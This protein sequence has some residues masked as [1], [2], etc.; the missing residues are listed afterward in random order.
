VLSTRCGRVRHGVMMMVTVGHLIQQ[1]VGR[2]RDVGVSRHVVHQLP[3][4]NSSAL[5]AGVHDCGVGVEHDVEVA[6]LIV[7]RRPVVGADHNKQHERILTRASDDS[8]PVKLPERWPAGA[9]FS[10]L[11]YGRVTSLSQRVR[12]LGGEVQDEAF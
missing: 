9:V 5:P 3:D 10:E 4:L 8:S 2:Q 11:I 1:G 7:A 6:H 12:D